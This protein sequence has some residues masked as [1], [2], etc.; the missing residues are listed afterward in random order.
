LPLNDPGGAQESTRERVC[1]P[2]ILRFICGTRGLL[3][4]A[5]GR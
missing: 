1:S 2:P 5:C 4:A 3:S